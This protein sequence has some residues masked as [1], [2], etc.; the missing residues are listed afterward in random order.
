MKPK[1]ENLANIKVD[2]YRLISDA[3]ERGLEAGYWKAHKYSD[4]PSPEDVFNHQHNYVM[5]GICEYLDF[6]DPC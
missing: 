2:V 6:G 3:V 5:N 4:K 1:V